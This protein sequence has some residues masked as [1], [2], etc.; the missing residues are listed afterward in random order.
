METPVA[1]QMP[2]TAQETVP[3]AD[4]DATQRVFVGAETAPA[5]RSQGPAAERSA[6]RAAASRAA[7]EKNTKKRGMTKKDKITVI[8][9]ASVTVLLVIALIIALTSI[10][11]E[12]EDDGLI[13]KGVIAAGVNIGGMTPDEAKV[14]LEQAT[15]NTYTE[16]DMSITVLDSTIVLSP[17]DTGA[18]L[19]IESV[20]ADAFNYGRTGSR[21]ERQQAKNHALANSYIVPIT[22][23]L[24]LDTNY[25][26]NAINDLGGQFSSTLSQPSI[27]VT[28]TRPEMGV[29]TPNTQVVHQTMSIYVGTAEYG[30]DTAKLYDKVMEYYNINIFQ[31]IGECT[32]VAPE[33]IEEDLLAQYEQLCVVP[34]DAE[35][36]PVT[37]AITPEVYGYGFDLDE[38]K[39]MI[40]NAAYGTTLEI[41]LSYI[42]PNLT[43]ALLSSNL[44]KETLSEYTSTL[45]I[46]LSWNSNVA[47]ACKALDGLILKSGD[48]LS[49]NDILGDLT[50]ENGYVAAMV[51]VGKT[52]TS[53]IG[54]GVSHVASVLYNC[55]LQAGLEI[56]EHHNHTYATNFIELG[57]DA[58]VH[59]G[60]A[61]FQFRN[62]LPDPIRLSVKI[63]N[64]A[65]VIQI[66]GTNSREYLIETEA[67]LV[68]TKVPGQ[69]YNYMLPTNPG[70]YVNGQVLQAGIMGYDVE[71]YCYKYD[72]ATG[73]LLE[74]ELLFTLNYES[75]DAVVVRLQTP[76]TDPTEP[77]TTPTETTEPT[78]PSDPTDSTDPTVEQGSSADPA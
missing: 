55:V 45:G 25:I 41:P 30:L 61:D 66:I 11:A 8:T 47:K 33:S 20:V 43:E 64:N 70:G 23:Y 29:P 65:I 31:V 69:L 19:D 54:G 58:Y 52:P 14:A 4:Q 38:V 3:V 5:V 7:A 77:S 75:R 35:I 67:L 50:M 1:E 36:D 15:A 57:H 46:D 26:R 28:G 68:K 10:L 63:V 13:L 18:R 44:F 2:Q 49:F 48:V 22:S 16:L 39:Q 6:A 73:R 56:V 17:Q 34:V 9:I 74:K 37:Y 27:T 12:P 40:A 78:T 24:N 72:K 53:V 51:Y 71:I 60:A 76:Q 32:V 59:T 21:A 62:S 42:E